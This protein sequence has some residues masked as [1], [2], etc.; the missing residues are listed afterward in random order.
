MR[1]ILKREY[2]LCCAII[3]RERCGE[4]LQ[5]IGGYNNG[6]YDARILDLEYND[7]GETCRVTP[8]DLIGDYVEGVY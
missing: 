4:R 2:G 7:T 6:G 8:Y 5:I 1:K 3:Y